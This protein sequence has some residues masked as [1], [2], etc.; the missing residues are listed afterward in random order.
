MTKTAEDKEE[1]WNIQKGPEP[2]QPHGWIQWKGTDVCMDL[3]CECGDLS[4]VDGSFCYHVKCPNCGA[5]Y[6]CN[7]HIELIKLEKE[8]DSCVL[9]GSNGID[10]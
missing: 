7:G 2:G 4:H 5:V 9:E 10:I 3:H 1:A 8:P 6:F